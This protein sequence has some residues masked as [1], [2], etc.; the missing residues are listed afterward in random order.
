M[1][2]VLAA[3]VGLTGLLGAGYNAWDQNQ[4][5]TVSGYFASAEQLV[6][7][8]DVVLGGV[9]VGKVDQVS[10]TPETSQAGAI[11]KMQIDRQFA[12]LHQGTRADIRPKGLLGVMYVEL[13]PGTGA[14][15]S[16]GGSI[17]LQDTSAPVT[18]DQINDIFDTATRQ[19]A[20]TA[21]VEGG[22]A[23]AGRGPDL[24]SLLQQLPAI[25]RDAADISA[26]LAQ[27]DQQLDAL[28]VEFDKVA[29]M[30]ADESE[31]LK[32]DLANGGELLQTIA[33]HEAQLQQELVYASSALAKL[34]AALSGHE[35]DLNQILKEMPALLDDLKSF[36]GHSATA[37][38]IVAPCTGDILATLGEMQS[39][40]NYKTPGGSTDGQGFELRTYAQNVGPVQ[41]GGPN[42]NPK[43]Y[44]CT[45]SKP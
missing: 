34:N 1:L 10:I 6:P 4:P 9:P 24:N 3:V 42:V 2:K 40:M 45:G 33:R 20:H 7:G 25:S 11:V 36:Q 44:P 15:L 13:K 23:F 38:S 29:R 5:Y 30:M 19:K 16:R 35:K 26:Q 18:L 12:P 21:T 14:L 37:L 32:R 8:N 43:L 27:R 17:P 22:K 39:A 41:G 31:S 28:A